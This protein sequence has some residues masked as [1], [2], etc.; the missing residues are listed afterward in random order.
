MALGDV[1]N[2]ASVTAA[3]V[4]WLE[5]HIAGILSYEEST[6]AS[7]DLTQDG[8]VNAAD[9]V[10]LASHIAGLA[11]YENLPTGSSSALILI[12]DTSSN[13]V[14]VRLDTSKIPN[15]SGKISGIQLYLTG[16]NLKDKTTTETYYSNYN[17]T[18]QGD[19]G[20]IVASNTLSNA[21]IIYLE[22][23]N[24]KYIE[25][26][27]GIMDLCAFEYDSI[28]TPQIVNEIGSYKSMI[29]DMDTSTNS[30]IEYDIATFTS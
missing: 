8:Q 11:G 10:W 21:S 12:Q 14:T 19:N 16:V 4:V 23:D 1:N 7:S 18:L 3:D 15:T 28:T 30:I 9:V 20:W 6:L 26:S 25:K 27:S 2:D 24:D 13:T 5:S 17:S 22:K 29:V